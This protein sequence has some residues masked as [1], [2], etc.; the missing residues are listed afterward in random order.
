[1]YYIVSLNNIYHG[2]ACITPIRCQ[3]KIFS[4]RTAV[5][6]LRTF[7]DFMQRSMVGCDIKEVPPLEE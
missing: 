7:I 3:A 1:M 6:L 2:D 4:K 5:S